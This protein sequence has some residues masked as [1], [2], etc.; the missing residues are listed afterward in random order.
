[1]VF[2]H[3]V[4]VAA[5]CERYSHSLLSPLFIR[6][7][8]LRSFLESSPK[9]STSGGKKTEISCNNNNKH[10]ARQNTNAASV[11][12]KHHRFSCGTAMDP[13]T[14]SL[15]HPKILGETC[16]QRYRRNSWLHHNQ[17]SVVS[18]PPEEHANHRTN[19]THT[20]TQ[21]LPGFETGGT[22]TD[23]THTHTPNTPSIAPRAFRV[24]R[25]WILEDHP[26]CL[27]RC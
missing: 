8:L 6:S 4:V 3:V 24:V 23:A 27:F 1:M 12:S 25:P 21:G 14:P 10:R 18:N 13:W 7:I 15:I 16:F 9:T 22:Q 20:H 11:C 5:R 26:P 19:N 2:F 17:E